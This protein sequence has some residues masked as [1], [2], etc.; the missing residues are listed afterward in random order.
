[1]SPEKVKTR[2][3]RAW[4]LLAKTWAT[5]LCFRKDAT[6]PSWFKISKASCFAFV[7]AK[8]KRLQ[9]RENMKHLQGGA[10]YQI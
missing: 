8:Q 2:S 4:G 10:P 1:M 3:I 6:S 5:K 7:L 9:N